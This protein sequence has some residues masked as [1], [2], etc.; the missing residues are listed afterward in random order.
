MDFVHG[1]STAV[2]NRVQLR[3]KLLRICEKLV[4]NM[5]NYESF[6]STTMKTLCV[7]ELRILK[8]IIETHD[9]QGELGN[10]SKVNEACNFT[11]TYD[12]RLEK[13]TYPVPSPDSHNIYANIRSRCI[14]R[15]L[16]HAEGRDRESS[17][18]L[19]KKLVHL[20]SKNKT[21]RRKIKRFIKQYI[22]KSSSRHNFLST[23]FSKYVSQKP[24]NVN[25]WQFVKPCRA[26][27]KTQKF[28]KKRSQKITIVLTG[29]ANIYTVRD[30]NSKMKWI[31]LRLLK[32]PLIGL[33][34]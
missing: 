6:I 26:I 1:S 21:K 32:L 14:T 29:R 5:R 20:M 27:K 33:S 31:F 19:M 28:K 3:E 8:R 10:I 4:A 30:L 11:A 7:K 23:R 9:A 2:Q 12:N 13:Q 17:R 25:M 15:Y 34:N 24:T 18:I 16:A 22:P